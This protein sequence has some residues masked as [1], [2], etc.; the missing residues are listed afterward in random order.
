MSS[1]V[2]LISG[3]LNDGSKVAGV[4]PPVWDSIGRVT[5]DSEVAIFLG[6]CVPFAE[7]LACSSL[8]LCSVLFS[9]SS[10]KEHRHFVS[11]DRKDM[12]D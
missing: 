8:D 11:I 7:E 2:P 9:P 10:D 6:V 1:T 12:K 3:T 4:V 5:D